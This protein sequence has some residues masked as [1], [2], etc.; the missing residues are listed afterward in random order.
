MVSLQRV[1]P[2][3]MWRPHVADLDV[4]PVHESANELLPEEK[5]SLRG[6]FKADVLRGAA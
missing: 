3:V 2:N 6:G 1:V 4:A 5:A